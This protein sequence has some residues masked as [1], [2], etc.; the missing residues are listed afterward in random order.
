MYSLYLEPTLGPSAELHQ[1]SDLRGL[2]VY[3]WTFKDLNEC[4]VII[5]IAMKNA[6]LA[7]LSSCPKRP[8]KVFGIG[9]GL[10]SFLIFFLVLHF[11]LCLRTLDF[12]YHPTSMLWLLLINFFSKTSFKTRQICLFSSNFN[13][14]NILFIVYLVKP[15]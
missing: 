1:D 2:H 10:L 11:R 13:F 15:Y 12:I 4:F 5:L 3:I 7:F 6:L 14:L 8:R 9:F